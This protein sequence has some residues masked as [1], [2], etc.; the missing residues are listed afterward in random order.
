MKLQRIRYFVTLAQTLNFSRTAQIHYVS[1]TTVSQ[2]IRE[3]ERELGRDLFTRTKRKVE[4]TPA[5][6]LFLEEAR[7]A[8][9][10]LDRADE[11]VRLLTANDLLPL[12]IGLLDG[13]TPAYIAPTL[14]AFKDANPDV[15]VS[16]S[17]RGVDDLYAG[18]I[19]GDLDVGLAYDVEAN[20]VPDVQKTLLARLPQYVVVSKRSHLAQHARLTREQLVGERC[21][22]ALESRGFIPWAEDRGAPEGGE[23]TD[24]LVE[25]LDALVLAI[26]LGEG[27]T[28]LAEPVVQ[29]LSASLNLAAVPLVPLEDECVPLVA[30]SRRDAPGAA[31]GRF[32]A[33]AAGA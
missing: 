28:L 23:R 8:L 22:N 19:A 3:L 32:L 18:V 6:K 11:R 24:V 21:V 13:I 27:Y 10:I 29:T 26:S 17:Y 33:F 30:L 15:A 9:D 4:L 14:C 7:K 2:Q 5:G 1:Q 31:V 20:E 12:K 25:S 16:F